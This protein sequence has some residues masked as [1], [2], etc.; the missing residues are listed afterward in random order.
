LHRADDQR[1]Q[2]VDGELP[3]VNSARETTMKLA[4]IALAAVFALSGTFVLAQSG[5][6]GSAGRKLCYG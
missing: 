1:N 4:T 2:D 6:S 3:L 5:G